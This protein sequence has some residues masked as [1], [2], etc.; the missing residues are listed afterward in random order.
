VDWFALFK[1]SINSIVLCSAGTAILRGERPSHT[2]KW[3]GFENLKER[4][5]LEIY[6]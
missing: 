6:T 4:D 2:A 3:N 1:I 5:Y